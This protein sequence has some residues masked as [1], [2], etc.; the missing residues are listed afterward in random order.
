VLRCNKFVLF[1]Y[2]KTIGLIYSNYVFLFVYCELLL[3]N[4][5]FEFVTKKGGA[6]CL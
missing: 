1:L 5:S 3:Q 6:F 2:L 4:L